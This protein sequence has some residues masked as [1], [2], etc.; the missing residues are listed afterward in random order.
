MSTFPLPTSCLPFSA[1]AC[2]FVFCHVWIQTHS[3]EMPC[4]C[5][6][7]LM[8]EVELSIWLHDFY[9]KK[10]CHSVNLLGFYN[11]LSSVVAL[12]YNLG[13]KKNPLQ[14]LCDR[15]GFLYV[16]Y[17]LANLQHSI[18]L[19]LLKTS[20]NCSPKAFHPGRCWTVTESDVRQGAQN[21]P[22]G[23]AS[24]SFEPSGFMVAGAHLRGVSPGCVSASGQGLS[25]FSKQESPCCIMPPCCT[26]IT[27]H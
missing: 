11:E 10:K 27:S 22:F 18:I 5:L 2:T 20:T 9:V 21:L 25:C 16:F 26:T 3:L 12:K 4:T 19:A 24:R 1:V 6:N 14:R 23:C 7:V 17:L 8:W 13:K 15:V